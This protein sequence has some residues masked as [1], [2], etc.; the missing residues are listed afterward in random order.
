MAGPPSPENPRCRRRPRCRCARRS[1][2]ARRRCRC[3]PPPPGPGL[4]GEAVS[5]ITRLPEWSTATPH[6]CTG[7]PWSRRRHRRAA[8]QRRCPPGWS[9]GRCRVHRPHRRGVGDVEVPGAERHATRQERATLVALAGPPTPPATVEITPAAGPSRGAPTPPGRAA[10]AAGPPRPAP[11]PPAP[12]APRRTPAEP[13]NSREPSSSHRKCP[14]PPRA[15]STGHCRQQLKGPHRHDARTPPA[16]DTI[17]E[18]KPPSGGQRYGPGFRVPSH[19]WP[20]RMPPSPAPHDRLSRARAV[21]LSLVI[22]WAMRL[23]PVASHPARPGEETLGHHRGPSIPRTSH[24][25]SARPGKVRPRW[26]TSRWPV[27]AITSSCALVSLMQECP[28]Q[29]GETRTDPL[30]YRLSPPR[31]HLISE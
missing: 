17:R 2:P 28:A 31:S 30:G 3:W 19:S 27:T 1:S 6:V 5:A 13:A 4:V 18:L 24:Q 14:P 10:A 11:P 26:P 8:R 29:P 7:L 9:A 20:G 16:D 25:A 15:G 12:P 21:E 23:A 22:D